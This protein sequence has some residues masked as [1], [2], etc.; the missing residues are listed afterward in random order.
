MY[1]QNI[2]LPQLLPILLGLINRYIFSDWSF[3]AFLM[4]AVSLDTVT[5]IW[6][7]YKFR[8]IHSM[9]LRKQFCEKVAQYGVGLILVHILSSHLVD[10][11]PNQ[12]FNT[13][14]PYFKGVMYM[15]FL[16]AECISVDENMG[17]LGLPFLPKWF[18]RRMQEFN[19]TG[20]LPPPPT[21]IT[22]ETENQSN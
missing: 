3:I 4:V 7:A 17:K 16:G 19:E 2:L 6:V 12:A 14:M 22:S 13:L 10:G 8:K 11:Q 15:V 18:R 5:G 21:K 20:V 1:F 9:R